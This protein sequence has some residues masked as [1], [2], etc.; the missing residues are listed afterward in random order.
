M[1]TTK[2]HDD[3]ADIPQSLIDELEARDRAPALITARADRAV[4]SMARS[5]F[6]GRRRVP[7]P[8]WLAAAAAAAFVVFLIPPLSLDNGPGPYRDVDGSGRIDIADVYALARGDDAVSQAELDAF[9]ARIVS[10]GAAG[11]TQ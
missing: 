7:R 5:H 8:A 9:A 10:L 6:A 4:R 2:D 1:T 3:R 11:E